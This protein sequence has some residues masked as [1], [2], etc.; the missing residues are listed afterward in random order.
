MCLTFQTLVFPAYFLM[1]QTISVK[2]DERIAK[3]EEN[4]D[5]KRND[6]KEGMKAFIQTVV[7]EFKE[8][9]KKHF[10]L[11]NFV[12]KKKEKISLNGRKPCFSS[13]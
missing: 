12:C 2:M 7:A 13:R 3:L 1:V 10:F 5:V 6:D 8:D 11:N 4:F 9:L